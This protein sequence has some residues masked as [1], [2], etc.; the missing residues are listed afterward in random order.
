MRLGELVLGFDVSIL[1][2]V[3]FPDFTSELFVPFE[4]GALGDAELLSNGRKTH[5][6]GT[7]FY[8]TALGAWDR[9]QKASL[10]LFVPACSKGPEDCLQRLY[11]SAFLLEFIDGTVL[12]ADGT[13][14]TSGL[15]RRCSEGH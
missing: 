15:A 3:K 8:K 9:P 11:R 14:G 13:P 7:K 5:A 6:I 1:T 12:G 2:A 10:G 4:N